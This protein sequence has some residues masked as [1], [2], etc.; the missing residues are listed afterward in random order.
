MTAA[1][2][3]MLCY[4]R[5]AARHAMPCHAHAMRARCLPDSACRCGCIRRV[6]LAC[7]LLAGR[8]CSKY[9]GHAA[10]VTV[11]R[12]KQHSPSLLAY[13]HPL[14]CFG[15]QARVCISLVRE[16]IRGAQGGLACLSKPHPSFC[17]PVVLETYSHGYYP[18]QTAPTLHSRLLRLLIDGMQL[19]F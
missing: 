6:G 18:T 5:P 12:S 4:P 10:N 15:R 11:P 16:C 3:E 2:H 19:A 17:Q 1:K 8:A 14:S 9:R 13:R 7:A